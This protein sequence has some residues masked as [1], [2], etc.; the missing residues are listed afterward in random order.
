MGGCR[1]C[2]EDGHQ[3][4]LEPQHPSSLYV[5]DLNPDTATSNDHLPNSG[6]KAVSQTSGQL[7]R[8]GLQKMQHNAILNPNPFQL[9][10][11]EAQ[12]AEYIHPSTTSMASHGRTELRYS[13]MLDIIQQK[14][15]TNDQNSTTFGASKLILGTNPLSA[16]LVGDL[17][18]RIVTNS[19]SFRTPDPPSHSRAP[20]R[21]QRTGIGGWDWERYYENAGM[22]M[23]R[24]RYLRDIGCFEL[25]PPDLCGRLLEVFFSHVHPMLPVID[26]KSFL[27]Q[28][29]GMNNPPSLV[30]LHAVFLAAAR[31]VDLSVLGAGCQGR[32]DY[33]DTQHGKL[34]ALLDDD[35]LFDRLAIIQASLLASL[36]WEGREGTNSAVHSLSLA[37]RV[38]Q[39]MGLHRSFN[40]SQSREEGHE[41]KAF[42]RRLWWSIY[43]LDRFNAAQEGIPFTIN[44]IDCDTP[45]LNDTDFR[46]EDE[47]TQ[48]V[49]MISFRLARI[50]E[51]AIRGVYAVRG[52]SPNTT[53]IPDIED[54][55]RLVSKLGD[56][57]REIDEKLSPFDYEDTN[58]PELQW[59]SI[60]V[61]Q[62]VSH[63]SLDLSSTNLGSLNAVRILVHRPFLLS[64]NIVGVDFPLTSR[65][66]C[67][68]HAYQI[69]ATLDQ[70]RRHNKLCYSWPFTVYALVN[71]FLI[72]WYDVSSPAT[73]DP[74]ALKRA[75]ADYANVVTLLKDMGDTWWAA[76][77]KYQ[78]SI[79]LAK[80]AGSTN[81]CTASHIEH[82]QVTG[83]TVSIQSE[84]ANTINSIQLPTPESITG[85]EQAMSIFG[86]S[87]LFHAEFD[88]GYWAAMGLNFNQDVASNIFSI[89]PE[90]RSVKVSSD[91][92]TVS[93]NNWQSYT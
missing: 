54:R 91:Q 4:S 48:K 93:Y 32:R 42:Q 50:V 71:C 5:F 8:D 73:V 26:R 49:M 20:I 56:L 79:A 22:N 44:E 86:E 27:S 66:A 69:S 52:P 55:R 18:H 31:Y 85:T 51:E 88:S 62:Y 59:H 70:L 89:L 63:F 30:V 72:T 17:K 13:S 92:S 41:S 21:R 90:S 58:H 15:K 36:H 68:V 35:I 19:C 57:S 83:E 46:H 2:E 23:H 38:A 12:P 77:A 78:L 16:L 87:E 28:Y 60:L 64:S 47:L 3:C 43:T 37:V 45:D 33:C 25:P 39:E 75:K 6:D 9:I 74:L 53:L 76:A 82:I 61:C 40:E 65:E 84:G 1:R 11:N 14:T 24:L 34:K 67:R 80:V 7:I 29:Y 10:H 81:L